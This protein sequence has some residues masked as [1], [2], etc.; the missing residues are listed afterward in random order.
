MLLMKLLYKCV[1]DIILLDHPVCITKVL[2]QLS[3]VV[4]ISQFLFFSTPLRYYTQ[5]FL[6]C[7]VQV[8]SNTNT[9]KFQVLQIIWSYVASFDRIYII[10]E[11]TLTDVE[12]VGF[13]PARHGILW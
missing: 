12:V 8:G 2:F 10:P 3:T 9:L 13:R 11:Q 7:L 1:S 4:S 6:L 5:C